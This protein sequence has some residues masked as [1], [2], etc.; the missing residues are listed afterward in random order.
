[1]VTTIPTM[2]KNYIQKIGRD[3]EQNCTKMN[4]FFN[5]WNDYL[6]L[7]GILG[8]NQNIPIFPQ[9]YG[10]KERDEFYASVRFTG[11]GG[12]SGHDSTIIAYDALLGAL[13]INT[14]PK[15]AWNEVLLRG[16][17]HG[18][19]SDS[20]G[21]IAGAWYGALFGLTNVNRKH[22]ELLEYRRRM[23]A[24]GEKL[25]L[26]SEKSYIEDIPKKSLCIIL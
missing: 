25:L 23:E 7:R 1:M 3:V 5:M 2:V 18:G 16:A 4:Y 24:L 26:M 21:T 8:E 10:V 22:Y 15:N 20:T 14:D 12:S 6:R 19:D 11:W 17:L 9:N 13:Y